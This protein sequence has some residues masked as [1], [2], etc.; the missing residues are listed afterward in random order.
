MGRSAFKLVLFDLD[1][2]LA[3]TAPDIAGAVHRTFL[4]QSLPTP[5]PALLRDQI[6]HGVRAMITAA[7]TRPL[8]EQR[9]DQLL[10]RFLVLYRE[11]IAVH[12]RLF[13]GM[14]KVIDSLE[15]D[16]IRWGVVTNKRASMT[17]PLID[18][19]GLRQRT[20]CVVSGDSAA[21]AKPHP[22][23]ILLALE[24]AACPAVESLYV[25]DANNDVLAA[26]AT[27]MQVV[28]ANYGYIA[29]NESPASWRADGYIDK[30][31]E[32]LEWMASR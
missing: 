28:V 22:D 17:E 30:P 13:P 6:S 19:L 10:D 7:L 12:T 27:G 14:E 4:E 24:Q 5:D 11:N 18:A 32:L 2:T 8:S 16:H 25:G 1:G 31:L 21:R 29:A 3:D 20:A 9:I 23:P 15:S 26:R